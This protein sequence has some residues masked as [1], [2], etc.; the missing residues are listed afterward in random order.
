MEIWKDIVG[1]E[2]L[3][4]VSSL[5]RIRSLRFNKIRILKNSINRQG[6]MRVNLFKDKVALT[7]SV[8]QLVGINFIENPLCKE[9]VNHIDG[10]KLN[11]CV[12]NLEWSS[13]LENVRHAHRI[14]LNGKERRA[15]FFINSLLS[16]TDVNSIHLLCTEYLD[17]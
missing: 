3:Y 5:G 16:I 17:Q 15:R 4:Q 1:Y 8:H 10:N 12:E 11:N 14:G 7:C 13:S 2:N 9:Q 6:Y